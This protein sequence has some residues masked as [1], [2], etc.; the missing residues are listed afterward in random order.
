MDYEKIWKSYPQQLEI[1][2]SRGLTVD[3]ETKALNYL[4][5]IGY[6]RLSG[7]WYPFRKRIFIDGSRKN[8]QVLDE[9]KNGA[10]FKN[11]VEFYVFDKK[12]RLLVLDA[13]ERIEVALRVD[14]A[15]TLGAKDPLAHLKPELLFSKFD[16]QK[17]LKRH[18][19]LITQSKEDFIKHNRDK[20]GEQLPIWIACEIWD[21]GTLST[22]F[23][24][25]TQTDQD[26]IAKKYGVN[27]GRIFASWLRS[28]N[29]LR[30]VC[31]HHS[32][33]WNSNISVHPKLPKLG[34]ISSLDCFVGDSHRLVRP[35]L[36]LCIIRHCLTIINPNSSWANRL[37]LLLLEF[38]NLQHLDVNLSS[39]GIVD[40]WEEWQ[41]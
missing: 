23:A 32:R 39:M 26:V 7:Y 20:Y 11:A 12:L 33:L 31:A 9:F 3:D 30:N 25:M 19:D 28:L 13:L 4:E 15:Y 22:L 14:I 29:Y 24:G 41:W 1:L 16:H 17:W 34:V 37:K 2:K 27:N 10:T 18:N 38:P 6:Y 36:L 40:N 21:F 35:F 8:T 5:R